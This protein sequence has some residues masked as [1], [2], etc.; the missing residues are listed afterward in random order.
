MLI[1]NGLSL[2]YFWWLWRRRP[3]D[4]E[5]SISK[6]GNVV[7]CDGFG[8]VKPSESGKSID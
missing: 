8:T 4:L 1:G 5:G 2:W 7:V 3:L 6:A